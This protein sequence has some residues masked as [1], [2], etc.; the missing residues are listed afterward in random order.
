MARGCT[1]PS[2]MHRTVTRLHILT[3]QLTPPPRCP[4]KPAKHPP[5]QDEASDA[6]ANPPPTNPITTSI[7]FTVTIHVVPVSTRAAA[8][9][10]A[11]GDFSLSKTDTLIKLTV[12]SPSLMPCPRRKKSETSRPKLHCRPVLTAEWLGAAGHCRRDPG[13]VDPCSTA[14]HFSLVGPGKFRWGRG[15]CGRVFCQRKKIGR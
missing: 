9:P 4:P 1:K 11:L 10:F 13:R 14:L 3:A 7:S 8:L 2:S 12:L 5:I 15:R 6:V